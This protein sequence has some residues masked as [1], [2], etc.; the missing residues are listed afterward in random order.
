MAVVLKKRAVTLWG[1]GGYDPLRK[2]P[3]QS[4]GKDQSRA[5]EGPEQST[6]N[7]QSTTNNSTNNYLPT[8]V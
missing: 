3:E 1:S 6:G 2:G 7:D 4:T 5:R 8:R